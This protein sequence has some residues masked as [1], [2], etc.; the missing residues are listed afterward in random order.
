MDYLDYF[1][2]YRTW[3]ENIA[4]SHYYSV[5]VFVNGKFFLDKWMKKSSFHG[6]HSFPLLPLLLVWP[7]ESVY[8]GLLPKPELLITWVSI[9]PN[10]YLFH[11]LW[12]PSNKYM[13]LQILIPGIW[14]GVVTSYLFQTQPCLTESQTTKHYRFSIYKNFSTQTHKCQWLLN[15]HLYFFCTFFHVVIIIYINYMKSSI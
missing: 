15:F 13:T 9:L 14:L 6:S 11:M 3:P 2:D 12:L 10:P 4:V 8:S 1:I 7:Q 5:T